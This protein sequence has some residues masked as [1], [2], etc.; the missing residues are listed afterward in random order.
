MA[1]VSQTKSV[2][3]PVPRKPN[4]QFPKGVSGNKEGRPKGSKNRITLLKQSL[5]L[6]LREQAEDKMGP[7]MDKAVELALEGDTAMIK[8]LIELHMTKGSSEDKKAQEKVEI[9]ISSGPRPKTKIEGNTLDM[10]IE[11]DENV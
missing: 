6:Q 9:N 7:V 10:E 11:E 1:S 4:G 3:E 2:L 8:M 5:E